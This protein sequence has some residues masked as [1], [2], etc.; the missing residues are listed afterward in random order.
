MVITRETQL[1]GKSEVVIEDTKVLIRDLVIDDRD[2][3]EYL[4]AAQD[5]V[6][7]IVEALRLG[8]RIL[9]LAG[10]SGDVEM[11]KHEFD[12]MIATMGK[13]VENVLEEAEKGVS[14]R[15]TK[16]STEQL[17]K[18]LDGHR[19][20]INQEL[21]KL[22]GPEQANSV[23]RQ[24]DK[25]LEE[26]VK[27]YR[28]EL[29]QVLEKTDDPESPF[30]KLRKSVSDEVKKA[31]DGVQGLRDEVMKIV[32]EAKGVA[33]E[34]EKGTAKG[35][36]YQEVVYEHV[37]RVAG[38]FGDT[39][40]YTADQPGEK[41]KSKAG[42]VVVELN[43]QESSGIQLRIVFE[44]K[45]RRVGQDSILEELD[46]AKENRSAIAAIAV[47]SRDDYIHG[48]RTW[49]DYHGHRYICI[50]NEEEPD[51]FA[52]DYSYRCARIDALRSIEAEEVKLDLPAVKGV[53]KRIRGKLA[54]FQQMQANLTG[55]RGSLDK[56][57]GL[58]EDHK[59]AIRD[60]LDEIDGLF[61]LGQQVS[62][63]STGPEGE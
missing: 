28:R 4:A 33:A 16:F 14:D 53:L 26:Q 60:D 58:I 39:V 15:L 23:Q 20:E 19:K 38:I 29:T 63:E 7:A 18:S 31:V 8:V 50:L 36:T 49:R 56:V 25:M 9:R 32:G 43:P 46:E 52:L 1:S 13:N 34:R 35:R 42:D 22:F 55:A 45:N 17:Q 5:Q 30:N 2:L 21:I 11:V 24:I 62:V 61:Q 37:D 51:T 48:L 54:D 3:D 27:I 10:T 44:A 40:R 12:G 41:G 47:F 57:S 59:K 6:Q